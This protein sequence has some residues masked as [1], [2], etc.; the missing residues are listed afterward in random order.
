[1]KILFLILFCMLQLAQASKLHYLNES[2]VDLTLIPP[3][4]AS[5]SSL[6][7]QDLEVLLTYQRTRTQADCDQATYEAPGYSEAFFAGPYGPLSEAEALK[8]HDF[9][10]LLHQEAKFFYRQLKRK[11]ARPRPYERSSLVT[12]CIPLGSSESYPSGHSAT[13]ILTSLVY[14]EVFPERRAEFLLRGEAIADG[15]LI[16]GVH[17]PTDV[18]WGKFIG[19]LVFEALMKDSKF[20]E[21]LKHLKP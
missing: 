1:M 7:L 12:P 16:G 19:R 3:P 8:L 14:A 20:K 21:D 5:G 2:S 9:H 13:A 6:D 18:K 15:R 17:Y 11:Y 10:E 4:P